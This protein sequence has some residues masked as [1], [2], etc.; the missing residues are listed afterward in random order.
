MFGSDNNSLAVIT[1][2]LTG[3]HKLNEL[4]KTN[5]SIC[6]FKLLSKLDTDLSLICF[7]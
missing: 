1:K 2:G 5:L 6:K 7:S 4:S 3:S